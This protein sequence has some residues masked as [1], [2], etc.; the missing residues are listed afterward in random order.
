MDVLDRAVVGIGDGEAEC[1]LG[2]VA[3]CVPA[4]LGPEVLGGRPGC[5]IVCYFVHEFCDLV[6]EE[7]GVVSRP[8][9]T[10]FEIRDS[11][12]T[13][14]GH[15]DRSYSRMDDLPLQR[16]PGIACVEQPEVPLV[17]QEF[18]ANDPSWYLT[19][20]RRRFIKYR[21]LVTISSFTLFFFSLNSQHTF[22][23]KSEFK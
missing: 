7:A 14:V 16:P 8:F 19:C 18:V 5:G 4:Y 1:L 12:H 2:E 21:L 11:R 20:Q 23:A 13:R 22:T 17:A 15:E 6:V 3:V 10:A 9:R